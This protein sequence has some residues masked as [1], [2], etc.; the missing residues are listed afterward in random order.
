MSPRH[1][2][3]R[4]GWVWNEN[5]GAVKIDAAG[6]LGFAVLGELHRASWQGQC[7]AHLGKVCQGQPV[8]SKFINHNELPNATVSDDGGGSGCTAHD[9]LPHGAIKCIIIMKKVSQ[10]RRHQVRCVASGLFLKLGILCSPDVTRTARTQQKVLPAY[11]V[12]D[13]QQPAL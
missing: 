9:R 5:C 13:K 3:R 8:R 11:H 12:P 1:L 4:R 7:T 2:K 10:Q 6:A